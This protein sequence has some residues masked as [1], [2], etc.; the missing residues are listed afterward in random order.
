MSTAD[1]TSK[2]GYMNPDRN[3]L[4]EGNRMLDVIRIRDLK[5]SCIVGI[6]EDERV[7]PQEI[8]INIAIHAD[9]SKPCATDKIEDTIDYK[10][11]KKAV[12]AMVKSSSFYLIEKL[13]EEVAAICLAPAL[14]SSVHVTI[15]KPHALSYARS[16]CVEI[17][18]ERR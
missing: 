12:I 9:L 6:N 17:T 3:K 2:E 14:A 1:D 18:R 4:S 16:V 11:V 7:V 10:S 5:L 15:D 8:V 13:A